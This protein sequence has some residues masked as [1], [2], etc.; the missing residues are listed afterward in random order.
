MFKNRKQ[1]RDAELFYWKWP[2]KYFRHRKHQIQFSYQLPQEPQPSPSPSEIN[3]KHFMAHIKE[4]ARTWL[5]PLPT[6][7]DNEI[8]QFR[9]RKWNDDTRQIVEKIPIFAIE[10]S[11]KWDS[12][13]MPPMENGRP[14]N[15]NTITLTQDWTKLNRGCNK[16]NWRQ[17]PHR[18]RI[19]SF[20]AWV[21]DYE[22][23][24]IMLTFL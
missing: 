21:T 23:F 13:I 7:Y 3:A 18:R 19:T 16:A 14:A 5:D 6:L 8:N 9:S 22:H 20:E 12:S 11:T 15:S 4:N 17:P 1:D 10:N 24:Y 2:E